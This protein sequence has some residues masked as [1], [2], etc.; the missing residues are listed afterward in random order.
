MGG[1]SLNLRTRRVGCLLRGSLGP[2]VPRTNVQVA[3][4]GFAFCG[5]AKVNS[6]LRMPAFTATVMHSPES[7]PS[8]LYSCCVFLVR[9]ESHGSNG[10]SG[11][12][13]SMLET[14]VCLRPSIQ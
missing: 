7:Q 5:T 6:T 1:S 3:S 13:A 10:F 8:D 11:N 14:G 9:S 2:M 12:P 4:P